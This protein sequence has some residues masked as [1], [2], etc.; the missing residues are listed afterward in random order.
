MKK[1]LKT[2]K[3]SEVSTVAMVAGGEN[4]LTKVVHNGDL[5]E[6]VGFGWHVIPSTVAERDKWPMVVE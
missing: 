6:W 4:K 5:K 1:Q 3:Y 2:V